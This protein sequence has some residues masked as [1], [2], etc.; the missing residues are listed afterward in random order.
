MAYNLVIFNPSR[1]SLNFSILKSKT[2]SLLNYIFIVSV[3]TVCLLPGNSI[4]AHIERYDFGDISN[5]VTKIWEPEVALYVA[6]HFASAHGFNEQHVSVTKLKAG[7]ANNFI[8][9]VYIDNQ[10]KFVIKGLSSKKEAESLFA[11]QNYSK[12]HAIQ[13]NPEAA[14][15][16]LSKLIQY[17]TVKNDINNYYFAVLEAAQGKELFKTMSYELLHNKD[18]NK[19]KDIF[20]KIGRQTSELHK[21]IIGAEQFI[22]PRNLLS[23]IHDDFHP[24]NTFYNIETNIFSLIDN[25]SMG[26]SISNPL[27]IVREIYGIYEVPIIRWPSEKI[28]IDLLKDADPHDIA[29]IY[30]ELVMGMAAVYQNT[31]DAK[32]VFINSIIDLNNMAIAFLKDQYS[33]SW[34]LY[35]TDKNEDHIVWGKLSKAVNDPVLAE[36]YI[37]KLTI[38]NND[39][40]LMGGQ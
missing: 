15:I 18:I 32:N 36:N 3:L 9:L 35:P 8:Y 26:E 28:T 14:T 4:A 40:R 39:L 16:C 10:M 34:M 20:Y 6:K 24:E 30:F 21:S 29:S 12:L 31:Q 23:V 19:L 33:E 11:L 38:I 27:P 37:S 5:K 22:S 1:Y 13:N 7:A 25:D 17:Y 2:L